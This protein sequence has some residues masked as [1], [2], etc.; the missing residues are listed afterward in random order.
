[1]MQDMNQYLLNLATQAIAKYNIETETGK[2]NI[3]TYIENQLK[4]KYGTTWH[5]IVNFNCSSSAIHETKGFI[6]VCH[7]DQVRVL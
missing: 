5:Y 4:T 1:M 3:K 7:G 6:Q 2:Q